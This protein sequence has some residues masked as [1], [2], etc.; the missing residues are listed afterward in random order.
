[1][2]ALSIVQ[3]ESPADVEELVDRAR[4]GDVQAFEAIYRRSA[5]RI[6]GLCRRLSGD[7]ARAEDLTQ[8]AFL[9]IWSK[10]DTYRAGTRFDAW[11]TRVAVNVTLGSNRSRRR[12]AGR[13]TGVADPDTWDPPSP[14]P[15]PDHGLDLEAAIGTLPPRARR[16]FVLHDVEGFKHQEIAREMEITVGT[17]KAQ[18]FRARRILRRALEES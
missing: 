3:M 8:E 13:E 1:M 15:G 16:V 9:R 17:S 10:L 2:Q 5:P 12:L 6:Y 14:T 18:L 11:M 4:R 7:P